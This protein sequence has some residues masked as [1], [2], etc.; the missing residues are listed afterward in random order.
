MTCAKLAVTVLAVSIVK[1]QVDVVPEHAPLQPAKAEPGLATA[2]SVM[3][4][5]A[6]TLARQALLT[7]ALFKT[8]L[9]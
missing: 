2:V 8:A 6:V 7:P 3:L 4:A 5:P 1:L 9:Q